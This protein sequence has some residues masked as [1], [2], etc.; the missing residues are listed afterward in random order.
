MQKDVAAGIENRVVGECYEPK[1]RTKLIDS[2]L[3]NFL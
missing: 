3:R 2:T 1:R